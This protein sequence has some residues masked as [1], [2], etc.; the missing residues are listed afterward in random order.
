VRQEEVGVARDSRTFEVDRPVQEVF[1]RW[2]DYEGL[3]ELVPQIKEVRRTSENRSHWVAEARGLRAEWEAEVTAREENRR[4]AWR[5][6]S[7]FENAGEVLFDPIDANHTRVTVNFEYTPFGRGD[8]GTLT[9]EIDEAAEAA[10][11]MLEHR[12]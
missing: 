3:A 7:G 8:E 6:V 11:E 12:R 2:V 9:E 4:I 1:Q 10:Q 5:S